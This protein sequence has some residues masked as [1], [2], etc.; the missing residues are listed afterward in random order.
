MHLLHLLRV[1]G[2]GGE[3]ACSQRSAVRI[4]ICKLR[5]LCVLGGDGGWRGYFDCCRSFSP[6]C[7][8]AYSA[9]A[10][11]ARFEIWWFDF[12]GLRMERCIDGEVRGA[13]GGGFCSYCA[14]AVWWSSLGG[15]GVGGC[16]SFRI[17]WVG[18]C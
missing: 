8:S 11:G 18:T 17:V 3:E 2:V 5:E 16:C 6:E 14:G 12:K 10:C 7:G 15:A 4:E 13:A 1:V 9:V